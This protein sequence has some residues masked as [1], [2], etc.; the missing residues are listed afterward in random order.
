MNKD[1]K[2][3]IQAASYKHKQNSDKG[4][5]ISI[6]QKQV[7]KVPTCCA[8][9]YVDVAVL[10]SLVLPLYSKCYEGSV[11]ALHGHSAV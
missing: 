6:F 11:L 8:R 5:K 2:R 4:I 1:T 3:N 10:S 7:L 9:C